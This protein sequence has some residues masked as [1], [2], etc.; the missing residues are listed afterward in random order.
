M[1]FRGENIWYVMTTRTCSF[2]SSSSLPNAFFP[3]TR[4]IPPFPWRFFCPMVYK[5]FK[6]PTV[7]H[8]ILKNALQNTLIFVSLLIFLFVTSY[9]IN[10]VLPEYQ[11]NCILSSALAPNYQSFSFNPSLIVSYVL[12]ELLMFCSEYLSC[13]SFYTFQA[14]EMSWLIPKA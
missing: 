12:C 10:Y 8:S 2:P 4:K 7:W 13:V 14:S 9:L 6:E 5:L 1:S 3:T 11:N